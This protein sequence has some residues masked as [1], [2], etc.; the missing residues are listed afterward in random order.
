MSIE[1]NGTKGQA[2]LGSAGTTQAE[3][4]RSASREG[5]EAG[6]G[7]RSSADTL[8]LTSRASQLQRLE[9]KLR[10]LPVVD[11]QRVQEVQRALATGTFEIRPAR[12]A[13]KMLNFEVGLDKPN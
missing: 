8:S 12:I 11:T 7:T 4:S 2:P 9:E 5:S 13:E 1:I 10:D 6:G 3:A